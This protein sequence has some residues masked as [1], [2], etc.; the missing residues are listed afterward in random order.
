[1]SDSSTG[2]PVR[3]NADN[4][5]LEGKVA[6]VTGASKGIGRAT[7]ERLGRAGADVVVNYHTDRAGADE[8]VDELRRGGRRAVAVQADI[9]V[10]EQVDRLFAGFARSSTAWT[11]W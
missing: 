4:S 6:L 2:N 5:F 7:A 3:V 9:G 11:S 8:V 10:A 1:M